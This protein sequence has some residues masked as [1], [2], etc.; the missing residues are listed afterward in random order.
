MKKMLARLLA[1]G[2]AHFIPVTKAEGAQ[3]GSVSPEAL[4]QVRHQSPISAPRPP[5]LSARR[6]ADSPSPKTAA[7]DDPDDEMRGDSLEAQA[8]SR[9]RARCA[10]IVTSADGLKRPEIAYAL[11][12][13]TRASLAEALQVLRGLGSGEFGHLASAPAQPPSRFRLG[14][15]V[16]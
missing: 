12:F 7:S 2:L 13:Q 6:T 1:R 3:T 4:P 5:A 15:R 14:A 10:A 9:E 16:H 8:R 11:A